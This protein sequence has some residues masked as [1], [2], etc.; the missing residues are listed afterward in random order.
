MA[1]DF[2]VIVRVRHRFGDH[3]QVG[4]Q[5]NDG[6][7]AYVDS[8]APFVGR[9]G[10]FA[11]SCPNVDASQE[12]VLQFAHRGSGQGLGFP[13]ISPEGE[14]L[15]AIG[16]EH[17]VLINGQRLFG[18]VSAAPF[19]FGN[20]PLWSTRLLIVHPGVLRQ[21]NVL[22]IE[23]GE[24][25]ATTGGTIRNLDD[26]TIDNVVIFFKTRTSSG[27]GPGLPIGGEAK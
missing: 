19:R 9:A 15:V 2:T 20:M 7:E 21:E 22:R 13:D 18:G 24:A 17:P 25:G 11:F 5:R 3:R 4:D 14:N 23:T 16:P 1:A 8:A 10:E 6:D 27:P 26:F 12:A